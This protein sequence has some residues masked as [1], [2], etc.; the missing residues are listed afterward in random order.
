MHVTSS[1]QCSQ[2]DTDNLI[3]SAAVH[4]LEAA[5]P[6]SIYRWVRIDFSEGVLSL[7]G[8]TQSFYHKQLIQEAVRGLEGV[9]SVDNSIDVPDP[10]A[11]SHHS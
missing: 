8:R 6:Q 1:C 2:L 9:E 5:L 4:R 10:S 3:V 11:E 7:R